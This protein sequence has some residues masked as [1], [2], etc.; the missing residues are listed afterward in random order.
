[1][2]LLNIKRKY[3]LKE[4]N[5][6]FSII[7][8]IDLLP[9]DIVYLKENDFVPCDGLIIEGECFINQSDLIG[10][11]NISK[12]ISL[13]RNN[14]YF[15]YKYSNNCILYHGMKIMNVFSKNNEGFI[16]VLCINTGA[17]TMKANQF[18]NI[19]Y[20]ITKNKGSS[21]YYNLF[22]ERKRIYFF[23]ATSFLMCAGL[24][25]FLNL[26]FIVMKGKISKNI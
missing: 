18:S 8:N 16:T 25:Y 24:G 14:K 26:L 21:F 12:K 1:M 6:L 22:N 7:N 2:N 20:F 5:Q 10:N 9:G 4:E 3:L 19:L 23:M 13:K 17:N 15:N 11:L